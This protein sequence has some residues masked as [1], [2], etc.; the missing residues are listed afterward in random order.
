MYV[1]REEARCSSSY[2]PSRLCQQSCACVR[3]LPT[4]R[5]REWVHLAIDSWQIHYLPSVTRFHAPRKGTCWTRHH[6]LQTDVWVTWPFPTASC[7]PTAVTW[8]CQHC[9][10]AL[11]SVIP[12]LPFTPAELSGIESPNVWE[13]ERERNKNKQINLH[14][15]AGQP[16]PVSWPYPW[17]VRVLSSLC[18]VML[19]SDM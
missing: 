12:P 13:W 17:Q 18:R 5:R 15:L 16:L 19:S 4:A 11:M 9:Q 8:P 1:L 10:V 2:L 7:D 6:E 3:F 14:K